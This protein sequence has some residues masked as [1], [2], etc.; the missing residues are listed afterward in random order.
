MKKRGHYCKVCG[1]YTAGLLGGVP[2]AFPHI[3]RKLPALVPDWLI[4]G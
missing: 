2:A 4:W 1:E 3:G